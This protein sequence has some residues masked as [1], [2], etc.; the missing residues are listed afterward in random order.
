LSE[1]VR[2]LNDEIQQHK[3]IARELA[4]KLDLSHNQQQSL[5]RQLL[6]KQTELKQAF[7][8]IEKGHHNYSALLKQNEYELTR[9]DEITRM[10]EERC[11][12]LESKIE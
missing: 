4:L 7:D 8:A 10:L 9:R 11:R 1:T 6:A 12:Q 3:E 5:E 2:K